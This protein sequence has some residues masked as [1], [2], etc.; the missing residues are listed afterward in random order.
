MYIFFS[1]SD[2]LS[3]KS[4][5]MILGRI[6][7]PAFVG[8]SSH[9][10]KRDEHNTTQHYPTLHYTTL[11]YTTLHYTTLHYT[12][13][14]GLLKQSAQVWRPSSSSTLTEDMQIGHIMWLHTHHTHTHTPH[15]HTHWHFLRGVMTS[16]CSHC[17][18][19]F[20][21]TLVECQFYVQ[22]SRCHL[23]VTS[24]NIL[25]SNSYCVFNFSVFVTECRVCQVSLISD[26]LLSLWRFSFHS[27]TY[28]L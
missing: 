3:G 1:D 14:Y 9:P 26:L 8:T 18:L 13:L 24:R 22:C 23:Q 2:E 5:N 15:T 20:C 16:T 12:K 17:G 11:H 27:Q 21:Y 7:S 28:V 10:G 6:F 19:P 25:G 4:W